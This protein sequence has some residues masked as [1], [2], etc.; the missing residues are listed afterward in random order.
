MTAPRRGMFPGGAPSFWPARPGGRPLVASV[1]TAR[2]IRGRLPRAAE[3][4]PGAGHDRPAALAHQIRVTHLGHRD[5]GASGSE[6]ER[7]G[8]DDDH[9][10]R[11]RRKPPGSGMLT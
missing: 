11:P 4:M 3:Y 1:R 2:E 6:A 8:E 9:S 10:F 7:D 5:R